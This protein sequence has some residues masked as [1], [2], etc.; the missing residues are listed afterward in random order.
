V[1]CGSNRAT[2]FSRRRTGAPEAN[3]PSVFRASIARP[4][5]RA[6]LLHRTVL[7]LNRYAAAIAA[8]PNAEDVK[9]VTA[10]RDQLMGENVLWLL[11]RYPGRKIIVWGASSHGAHDLRLVRGARWVSERDVDASIAHVAKNKSIT[12]EQALAPSPLRHCSR[13]TASPLRTT[14]PAKSWCMGRSVRAAAGAF[15]SPGG[16]PSVSRACAMS[17][18]E[19]S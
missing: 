2:W 9:G 4:W 6:E 11:D 19:R 14:V 15:T 5:T 12:S 18:L 8:R 16:R 10:E 7:G 17:A 1:R 3:A 13:K